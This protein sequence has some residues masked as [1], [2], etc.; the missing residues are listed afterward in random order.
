M[1]F[2]GLIRFRVQ[3]SWATRAAVRSSVAASGILLGFPERT[4]V[5][6]VLWPLSAAPP[7]VSSYMH[8]LCAF[9][10]IWGNRWVCNDIR[11]LVWY[12]RGNCR[13]ENLQ[14]REMSRTLILTRSKRQKSEERR[15]PNLCIFIINNVHLSATLS[16]RSRLC[17]FALLKVPLL[18]SRRSAVSR[19]GM[20]AFM[21]FCAFWQQCFHQASNFPPPHPFPTCYQLFKKIWS[22]M[23]ISEFLRLRRNITNNTFS[24]H[25][26]NFGQK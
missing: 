1:P 3:S 18:L 20:F 15:I 23:K 11:S 21:R 8:V 14:K 24:T 16:L 19:L 22:T 12:L 17:H 6:F 5:K 7:N 10:V 26:A 4:V 13:K 25:S 2:I 9:A